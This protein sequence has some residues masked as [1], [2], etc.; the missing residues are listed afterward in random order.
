MHNDCINT[1]CEVSVLPPVGGST[2]QPLPPTLQSKS[3]DDMKGALAGIKSRGRA[4]RDEGGG[5][6]VRVEG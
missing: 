1:F 6:T 5:L 4:V 3:H 2:P